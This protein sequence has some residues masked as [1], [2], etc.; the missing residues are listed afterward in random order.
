VA[1]I[2]RARL[3]DVEVER[4]L[5]RKLQLHAWILLAQLVLQRMGLHMQRGHQRLYRRTRRLQ[6][7][8]DKRPATFTQKRRIVQIKIGHHGR[9]AGLLSQLPHN[10]RQHLPA[11]RGTRRRNPLDHQYDAVNEG[12]MKASRQLLLDRFGLAALN[13]GCRLQMTLSVKG[14]RK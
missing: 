4:N 6:P 8:Q 11:L 12:R 10:G 14:E 3:A 9:H 7:N 2:I 13:A 1:H 5:A